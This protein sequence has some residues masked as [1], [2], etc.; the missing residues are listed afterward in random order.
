MVELEV[1]EGSEDLQNWMHNR[2]VFLKNQIH[3]RAK[4][5]FGFHS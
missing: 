4:D 1:Q 3:L 5:F 2:Y